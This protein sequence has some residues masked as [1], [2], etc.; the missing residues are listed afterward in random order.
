MTE[1]LAYIL[2]RVTQWLTVLWVALTV[3]FV[4]PNLL[5]GDPAEKAMLALATRGGSGQSLAD[6]VQVYEQR[7]G[8]HRPILER[9][10]NY[11]VDLLH[12]DLGYS[13]ADYPE[14]VIHKLANAIPWTVGLVATS[15][16]VAFLIG[17]IGGALLAWPPTSRRMRF[18]APPFVLLSSIPY[19]LLAI[20][21]TALFVT[22]LHL[23]P[24]A[25]GFSPT[26]VVRPDLKS[27]LDL[28][29]H[30]IL[31]F[32]SITLVAIGGWGLG[33]RSLMVG[34]L[35]EDYIQYAESKGLSP[36][37]IFLR[38]GMRTAILPQITALGLALGGM[39]GGVVLVETTF[40]YP[41]IGGLLLKA[42]FAKDIFV[43][44]GIVVLLVLMLSTAALLLD[45]L[46]PILDPRIRH[47]S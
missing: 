24:G 6:L 7:F 4:I 20:M 26:Q 28:G 34:V 14:L 29:A 17:S 41:G 18:L 35:G 5:P 46:Y 11:W 47:R 13:I 39:L 21:L 30:A 9:Y 10:L 2:G 32:L 19:F 36:R 12:F 22:A 45:L 33:M 43:V 1:T 42:I 3:N 37:R 31:P 8:L 27:F 16:L 25:G 38:Y 44:N 15:T 23:L 40:N